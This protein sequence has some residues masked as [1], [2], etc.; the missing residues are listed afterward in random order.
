VKYCKKCNKNFNDEDK[1]CDVCGNKL[2][3]PRINGN[4]IFSRRNLIIIVSILIIFI[5][6]FVLG[7]S[8]SIFKF[9]S[10]N[11]QT[12]IITTTSSGYAA[13]TTILTTTTSIIPTTTTE[14]AECT[15]SNFNVYA[16]SY[17]STTKNFTIMLEN[18]GMY[19]VKINKI[20]F[21]YADLSIESHDVN[22]ILPVG[23]A[24]SRFVISDVTSNYQKYRVVSS[25]P[26][27]VVEK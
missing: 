12:T 10:N 23:G 13:T 18:T 17:N 25:C 21:I 11:Q 24:V 6:V 7:S 9:T 4:K 3:S 1:F 2:I 8:F 14:T 16:A 15:G 20:D 5:F 22:G 26:Q 19:S 27:L